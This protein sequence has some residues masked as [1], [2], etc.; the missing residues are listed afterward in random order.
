M[1]CS[2]SAVVSLSLLSSST[3]AA[4]FLP[5]RFLGA[6]L[7]FF[8]GDS[9][10]PPS[11]S[12]AFLPRLRGVA[13]GAACTSVS[14]LSQPSR[15]EAQTTAK[16][17]FGVSPVSSPPS[18]P[19][20]RAALAASFFLIPAQALLAERGLLKFTSLAIFSKSIYESISMETSGCVE[21][22]YAM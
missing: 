18:P 6:A 21:A 16:H 1:T 17:T 5:P 8:A 2:T 11:S 9:P 12:A 10:S 20:P 22:C 4:A 19:S 3:S 7:C 14:Q 15:L 13:F